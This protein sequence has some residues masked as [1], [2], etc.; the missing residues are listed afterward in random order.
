VIG[1]TVALTMTPA[2][3][4]VC[5]SAVTLS[6]TLAATLT[7]SASDRLDGTYA[8]FACDG[9]IGGSIALQRQP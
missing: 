2:Q 3:P 1:S 7:M 5:S 4:L 6:G 9:A 8:A